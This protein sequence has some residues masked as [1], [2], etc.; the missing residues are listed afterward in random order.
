MIYTLKQGFKTIGFVHQKQW[1]VIGF[2][3]PHI[4]RTVHYSMNPEPTF[5]LIRGNELNVRNIT[6]DTTSTLFI[7]KFKG[8]VWEPLNDGG[9]HL[10]NMTEPEFYSLPLK[11]MGIV[12]PY[13]LLEESD[14]EFMFRSQVVDPIDPKE[15]KS[16]YQVYSF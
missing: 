16:D 11:G 4:A 7:P 8:N 6:F 2:R 5:T 10:G 14:I 1:Y 15:V 9:F 13:E 12:M 3:T